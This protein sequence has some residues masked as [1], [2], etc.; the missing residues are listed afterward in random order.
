[1]RSVDHDGIPVVDD[2]VRV[3]LVVSQ[4]SGLVEKDERIGIRYA[5]PVVTRILNVR[6]QVYLARHVSTL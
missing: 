4:A 5:Q 2:T 1:M 6:E 3:P